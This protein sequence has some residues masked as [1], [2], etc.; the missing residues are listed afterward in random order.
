[1]LTG[2]GGGFGPWLC[3]WHSV[4]GHHPG[5]G[6]GSW[7]RW[8]QEGPT[9]VLGPQ[10]KGLSASKAG[11]RGP[12]GTGVWKSDPGA[13]QDTVGEADTRGRGRRGRSRL[14][15]PEQ[16]PPDKQQP[17]DSAEGV[18]GSCGSSPTPAMGPHKSLVSTV[19][20]SHGMDGAAPIPVLLLPPHAHA[21]SC[22]PQVGSFVHSSP[23]S[24]DSAHTAA[25][26]ISSETDPN[27][28]GLPG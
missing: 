11:A 6:W 22:S 7:R 18:R 26:S 17:Q 25:M 16:P 15:W 14:R 8:Q 21:V 28:R 20:P 10:D 12:A 27:P 1:M 13:A 23:P 2:E 9:W 24:S 3:C 4:W 19:N 5:F